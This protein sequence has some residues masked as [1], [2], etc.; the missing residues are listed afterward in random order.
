MPLALD[1]LDRASLHL[2]QRFDVY[3]RDGHPSLKTEDEAK[4]LLRLQAEH[5]TTAA[6]ELALAAGVLK[7]AGKAT[8]A[9]RAYQA[10]KHT[11]AQAEILR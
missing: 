4:A 3:L 9:S 7:S 6:D 2:Q 8:A 5:L 10:Y 1:W 11:L